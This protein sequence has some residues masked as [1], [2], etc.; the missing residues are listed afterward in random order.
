MF[1]VLQRSQ[2]A[3][4]KW[5]Y[6]RHD[7]FADDPENRPGEAILHMEYYYLPAE[8]REEIEELENEL[9]EIDEEIAQLKEREDELS[10]QIAEIALPHV[11][12]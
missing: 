2:K 12:N 5:V 1:D 10:N 4:L 7:R 9:D 8:A 6:P 11:D 3:R